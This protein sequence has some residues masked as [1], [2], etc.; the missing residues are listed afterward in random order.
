MIFGSPLS[1][2]VIDTL[3]KYYQF[4]DI[5]D[6]ANYD[7]DFASLRNLLSSLKKDEFQDNYRFI[8]FNRESAFYYKKQHNFVWYNLQVLLRELDIP[9]RFCI[10]ITQHA[11]AQYA[12][13]QL[14][15]EITY[16]QEPITVFDYY[17][18]TDWVNIPD[19]INL[20]FDKIEK[21]YMSLNRV[22]RKH[23][24]LAFVLLNHYKLLDRGLISYNILDGAGGNKHELT[25][26][27][28]S[29]ENLN[30]D[31]ITTVPFTRVNEDFKINNIELR[32]M[33]QLLVNSGSGFK[34]FQES[35][36]TKI[37]ANTTSGNT[38]LT[39][40]AFLWFATESDAHVPDSFLS[41][42]SIKGIV[43]KRP[44][45]I[46]S[47]PRTL[48]RLQHYGFKTFSDYWDESYDQVEDT[49]ERINAAINVVR[50]IADKSISELVQLG[51]DMQDV[52]EYNFEHAKNFDSYQLKKLQKQIYTNLTKFNNV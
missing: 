26:P 50:L 4:E 17:L 6:L 8:F 9:N 22:R 18:F 24:S 29:N 28:Y 5:I 46:L 39:Q 35:I 44:F 52:L 19:S 13:N 37:Y 31:Y 43:A 27:K 30:Y 32:N 45:V 7:F 49:E 40:R 33:F 48:Q 34:N 11:D 38:E 15:K 20:N 12:F 36:E 23:R 16:D 1:K 41:E 25:D 47:G 10:L 2:E 3:R 51:K 21:Q 14:Q 42:K